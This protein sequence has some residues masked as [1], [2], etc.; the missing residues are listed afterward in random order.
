MFLRDPRGQAFS[1]AAMTSRLGAMGG[2][3]LDRNEDRETII[4]QFMK[5]DHVWRNTD[6][7]TSIK[8]ILG[9]FGRDNVYLG[10]YE[11]QFEQAEFLRLNRYLGL[12]AKTG[13]LDKRIN[14]SRR[15]MD[16]SSNAKCNVFKQ[17][18]I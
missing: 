1:L 7:Q 4:R 11:K 12:E 6:Y 15:D 3:S 5:M 14:R 16:L 2:K 17:T 13:W 8:T 9:V 18:S 10:I